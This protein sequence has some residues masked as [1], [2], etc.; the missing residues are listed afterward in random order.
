MVVD[1]SRSR[2][3]RM[4]YVTHRS[5]GVQKDKFDVLPT[6]NDV[7][8]TARTVLKKLWLSFSYDYVFTSI[9]AKLEKVLV[10]L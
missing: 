7:W 10:Y 9:C 4:H 6:E 5:H 2:D 8:R 3:T 1:V